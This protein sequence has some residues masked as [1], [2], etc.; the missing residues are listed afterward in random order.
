MRL[1]PPGHSE[2]PPWPAQFGF[3]LAGRS[4]VA[5]WPAPLSVSAWL[6]VTFSVYAPVATTTVPPAFTRSTAD[7]IGP[8]LPTVAPL[9]TLRLPKSPAKPG[10]PAVALLALLVSQGLKAS[11]LVLTLPR[12]PGSPFGLGFRRLT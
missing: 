10:A 4:T 1:L 9:L 7:W 2:P 8:L 11:R 3:E 12:P 6:I 5:P